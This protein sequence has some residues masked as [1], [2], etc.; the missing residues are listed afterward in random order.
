MT[1]ININNISGIASVNAQSNSLELFDNT[2][3]SLLDLNA[4]TSTFPADISVGGGAIVG[5]AL[6]VTG[7]LTYDDVT[8]I[9]S[10][11][12]VT[13]RSGVHFGTAASGT[14]VVGDSDGIGIGTDN[15]EG[16][17]HVLASTNNQLVLESVDLY[18]DI[19]GADTGGSTRIRSNNG[20]LTF[21][22]GGDVSSHNA[23]GSSQALKITSGGDTQVSSGSSLYIANGNLVFSTSGTGIDFSATAN[24]SGTMSSELL[25][26]YEEGSWTPDV[27]DGGVSW[28]NQT[29]S[30]VK[31]GKQVTAQFWLQASGTSSS[32]G[33]FSIQGLPFASGSYSDRNAG[34]CRAYSL[35]NF[36]GKSG[37]IYWMGGST[38]SI[39]IVAVDGNGLTEAS[40]LNHN[41]WQNG[42]EIHCTIHY[43]TA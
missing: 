13:A 1:V 31:I 42:A 11:G 35:A 20:E 19:I 8:N 34:A 14:L 32:S 24:S 40:L 30:Y 29:G 25:D 12:V 36:S 22:T 15:P 16:T 39:N 33:G 37:V 3:A 17:I 41:V 28:G 18:A 5:G 23:S 9:D 43:Q 7:V 2:G 27:S 38:T 6:T 10:V 26:D 4:N 21:S